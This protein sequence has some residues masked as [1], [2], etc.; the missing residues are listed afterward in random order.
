MSPVSLLPL[1]LVTS[2]FLI[3]VSSVFPITPRSLFTFLFFLSVMPLLSFSATLVTVILA[4]AFG[5]SS[6]FFGTSLFLW[7]RRGL[8]RKQVLA[9]SNG[10]SIGQLLVLVGVTCSCCDGFLLLFQQFLGKSILF[11]VI[12]S[13]RPPQYFGPCQIIHSKD[14]ASS[15][16]VLAKGKAS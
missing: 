9:L 14:T 7:R 6:L 1:L 13:Q 12:N 3:I 16:F 8:F 15:I 11:T 5:F 10:E 2:F 4:L